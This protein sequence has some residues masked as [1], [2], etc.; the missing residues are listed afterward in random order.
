MVLNTSEI[1]VLKN[2]CSIQTRLLIEISALITM[3]NLIAS[4]CA[5]LHKNSL[6]GLKVCKVLSSLIFT[7]F[8]ENLIGH[9]LLDFY[10]IEK[11]LDEIENFG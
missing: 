11:L 10:E 1:D 6:G 4:T 2:V 3:S 8:F 5:N 9:L 7:I